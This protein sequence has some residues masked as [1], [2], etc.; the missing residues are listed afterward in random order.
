MG[1]VDLFLN[2]IDVV[3]LFSSVNNK[4]SVSAVV[5]CSLNLST[6]TDNPDELTLMV[7]FW[8]LK[9]ENIQDVITEWIYWIVEK[10]V[11]TFLEFEELSAK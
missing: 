9:D 5:D 3:V 4:H 10:H 1:K 11:M 2:R 8:L 6:L 7:T